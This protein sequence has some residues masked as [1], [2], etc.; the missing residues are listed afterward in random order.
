[1]MVVLLPAHFVSS[2]LYEKLELR[3]MKYKDMRVKMMN[4]I[5]GGIKVS[6][7]PVVFLPYY[8]TGEWWGRIAWKWTQG[9]CICSL[10]RFIAARWAGGRAVAICFQL[11]VNFFRFICLERLFGL[12]FCFLRQSFDVLV[13]LMFFTTKTR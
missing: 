5:L 1:M 2:R 9:G 13:D 6:E 4:E 11:Y 10:R 7:S 8:R 3:Q 12:N